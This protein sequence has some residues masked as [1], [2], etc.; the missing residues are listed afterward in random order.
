MPDSVDVLTV[1][2]A[3]VVDRVPVDGVPVVDQVSA[4]DRAPVVDQMPVVDRA[5]PVTPSD[6]DPTTPAERSLAEVLAEVVGVDRVAVDGHFFDDLGADSMVMARFC[7][8]LRKR[9]DLPSVSMKDIY[10]HPTIKDLAVAFA[11]AAPAPAAPAPAAAPPGPAIDIALAEVL[12]EVAGLDQVPPDGHFFDDLGADSMVM[13]RFCAR[14]RKRDDLPSVSMKDIYQHPTIKDLAVAFA[15]AAPAPAAPAPVA[16]PPGPAID[17]ALAEVLAEV[18]GLDQVPPDGHFFD[19]LGAD[20]MVMAR[21]CAR[22]RKRDDLPSVSMK[23]IYSHPTIKDL[24]AAFAPAA[25]ISLSGADQISLSGSATPKEKTPAESSDAAPVEPAHRA[26]TR[27][28][29][30]CGMAQFLIFLGTTL[31]GAVIAIQ[32]YEWITARTGWFDLYLRALVFGCALFLGS[33]LLSIVAKWVLIGRWKEQEIRVW[34]PAYLRFWVVKTLLRAN[35]LGRLLV[36]TPLYPL[37]LRALGA[38]VGRRVTIFTNLA[39]ICTDLLTIGSDSVIR[40]ES[41]FLCYR[42]HAGRIQT[43]RVSLGRNVFVGEKTVLDIGTSMGDDAQLG[44]SSALH[45]GQS[46]PDGERWHGSPAERTDVQYAWISPD[47]RATLRRVAYSVWILFKVFFLYVPLAQGV[48]YILLAEV[49]Y[50]GRLLVPG[51]INV[52]TAEFYLETVALASGLFFGSILVGLLVVLTVPRVLNLF[53]TPDTVYPLYGFHYAV[54]RTITRMTNLKFYMLLFGDTSYIVNYFRGIGYRLGRVKQTGSNFGMDQKHDSP[55]LTSVGGGTM[56][57]DGLSV[58]NTDYTGTSF[59]VSRATIGDNNFLGNNIAYPYG[60]RTGDNCLLATKV[61]VPLDGK[62]RHGV[63]LLGSPCFE[64]PRSVAR[65]S[66]FD[67]LRTEAE[68]RPHLAAKNR[69]DIRTMGVLLGLRWLLFSLLL[70][71]GLA[72]VDTFEILGI[73]G[74]AAYFMSIMVIT[75]G[76]LVLAERAVA[77]FKRLQP[78]YCSLYDP[79]FWWHERYWKVA[80]STFMHAFDGT[81]FKNMIWRLMGVRLGR[82]VFDDG[83]AMPE[84]TMVTIGDDCTLNSATVIQCHSQEDGA[85]KSDYITIGAGCTLGVGAFVHYGTT[86][87]DGAELAPDSFLMK[88]EEIPPHAYWGGNPAREIRS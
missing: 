48:I 68:I 16:A 10:Q 25:P 60:G 73:A 78:Q 41:S 11:P 74:I 39:P 14:L 35:P 66:G 20:S 26:S 8:R 7:A 17:I 86:M 12:A 72:A 46:V 84:R 53:I 69:Y 21:F 82:R 58:V 13:A 51:T 59:W 42:A 79:Y 49:P 65:D 64:I 29:V 81:P 61:M 22:L 43:G 9:D 4:V 44:H 57:A 36:G 33:T 52:A 45:R 28:F 62:V 32:G 71:F 24:A 70:T 2:Q 63:G 56:I 37:Y 34:S 27:A 1:D 85:F 15:P 75:A 80:S 54:Q 77:G 38:R 31:V 87:G 76:Y 23:D 47:E 5:E 3:P 6:T 55:F 83:C 30:L 50:L 40:K 18:A 19:D 67:G 88:G